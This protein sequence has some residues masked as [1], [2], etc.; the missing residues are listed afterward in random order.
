L[1]SVISSSS[2]LALG[3]DHR[4]A[5]A[6]APQ[7]LG[8]VGAAAH[9]RNLEG[10]LVDV[11]VLVGGGEH[12]A[13]VDE[14]HPDGLE[15]LR[16]GEVADARL[17]HDRDGHALHDLL[18]DAQVRHARHAALLADVGGHALEGH[19][20]DRTGV[21]GDLRLLGVGHVHDDAAAQHLGESDLG[22]PRGCLG[23]R[24]S[25]LPPG[26]RSRPGALLNDGK[27]P[28]QHGATRGLGCCLH[29]Q[30]STARGGSQATARDRSSPHR[31][32]PRAPRPWRVAGEQMPRGT[33][34][35]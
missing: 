32:V 1:A 31:S 12:L 30:D 14:V 24:R 6:D 23:H 20:G 17:G 16:L 5:L 25:L 35:H 21:L 10:V 9:E 29:V 22:S 15:H 19:D 34:A 7:G 3:A 8:Q 18:D 2:R 11:E 27:A 26:P 33:T 4:G 28:R 13:L